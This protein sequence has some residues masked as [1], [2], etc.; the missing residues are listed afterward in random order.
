MREM[1]SLASTY[2]R[3]QL[4]ASLMQ[5]L[6]LMQQLALATQPGAQLRQ[7]RR[8][9]RRGAHAIVLAWFSLGAIASGVLGAGT[10]AAMRA[11]AAGMS[12]LASMTALVS[13]DWA[14]WAKPRVAPAVSESAP[15]WD[16]I[17]L[18]LNRT[19]RVPLP[20]QVTGADGAAFEVVLDGLPA[21]VKPSRGFP[22][23]RAWVLAPDDL[24]GLFLTLQDA[25]PAA[26]DVRIAL[27]APSAVTTSGSIVQVRLSDPPPQGQVAATDRR[28]PRHAAPVYA[29]ITDGLQD[30]AARPAPA[31][32]PEATGNVTSRGES[33]AR[34]VAPVGGEKAKADREGADPARRRATASSGAEPTGDRHWPEGASALGA[35]SREPTGPS[36]W[37][38]P[39]PSWSPFVVGQERP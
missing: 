9:P 12:P 11:H 20:L 35:V 36:W 22:R 28:E 39:P 23:G 31:K 15:A 38:M 27:A 17:Q 29:S 37:Q 30:D 5:R 24:N 2:D 21:G 3:G 13:M 26:F 6:E 8:G 14:A 4:P 32:L 25:A 10:L 33:E 16:T 1:A 34:P 19:G 7:R 18:A